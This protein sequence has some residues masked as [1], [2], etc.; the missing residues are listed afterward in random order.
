MVAAQAAQPRLRGT[1]VRG[2]LGIWCETGMRR[3]ASIAPAADPK[4]VSA[5]VP[6]AVQTVLDGQR[7]VH[8]FEVW[9]PVG[10]RWRRANVPGY[11]VRPAPALQLLRAANAADAARWA[12]PDLR[13]LAQLA[14]GVEE[15]VG[16]GQVVP[17]VVY[18]EDY[19]ARWELLRTPEI[20][21][22]LGSVS[23]LV[24][25]LDVD[26]LAAFADWVADSAA[27]WRLQARPS[28]PA[29]I[30]GLTAEGSDFRGEHA[31][32]A[33]SR[34]FAVAAAAAGV[35]IVLRVLEPEESL[36]RLQVLVRTGGDGLRPFAEL[37]DP[38]LVAPVIA[39]LLDTAKRAYPALAQ[40]ETAAGGVDF[41]LPSEELLDFVDR[42]A[43]VLAER[44]IEVLLPRAWIRVKTEVRATPVQPQ[45]ESE[46]R[47]G[48]SQLVDVQWEVMVGGEPVDE[49]ELQRMLAAS[50]DLVQLRGRWVR[51]DADALRRAAAFLDRAR[52][53]TA[54]ADG[55]DGSDVAGGPDGAGA[56]GADGE[57]GP[58]KRV[59]TAIAAFVGA[60]CAPE[61]EGVSISAASTLAWPIPRE[62]DVDKRLPEWFGARLRDY[63]SDGV[64]W[65]AGMA[66]AG[67]GAVL[68]DDMGLGKTVQILALEAIDRTGGVRV[69][70][71][72]GERD[73]A[74]LGPTLIVAPLSL[75][76]NWQREAERF[77]PQLQVY[78]HHGPGR[79]AGEA[80]AVAIEAADLVLTTYGTAVRDIE[81]LRRHR[82]HRVVLDEA[83]TVKNADTQA[84]RALR[85]LA[86]GHR[87]ALTGTPVENR[88]EDMRAILDFCNPGMFGSAEVFR[89]RFAAAIESDGDETAAA[90]LTSMAAPFVLRRTKSDPRVLSLPA[91]VEHRVDAFLTNEQAALYTA[92]A[93]EMMEQV[94]SRGRQGRKGAI[95][96]GLTALKQVCDH[97]ALYAADGSA[98]LREGAHRSGKLDALDEILTT[99]GDAGEK[100]LVFTQYRTFGEMILPY[101]S[102]RAAEPVPF[103]SGASSPTARAEMVEAFQR[104]DGPPVFLASL[105]AGGTGLTLTAANHVV[106]LDRWWNPAVEDQ[107]TDRVHRIGQERQVNVYTL[108][109]PGTV[110]ERIA[111]VLDHKAG[112]AEITVGALRV[113][114]LSDEAL[115]DLVALRS[116]SAQAAAA[117]RLSTTPGSAAMTQRRRR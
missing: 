94:R 49:V 23:R 113:S 36:W 34:D 62:L 97:P 81:A 98:L 110:E 107:A 37:P 100:V 70:G 78:V 75:V 84:A 67:L 32:V 101:L 40:A 3:T 12:G 53:S 68:A 90:R 1:W 44:G 64:R 52:G 56:A 71:G 47:L 74:R 11:L 26:E 22:W 115:W 33:R 13:A 10:G 82:I 39:S 29:F 17:V 43:Q 87:V 27:R 83:Q 79:A 106:H 45:V 19:L 104:P 91:K 80:A 9:A 72:T 15:L 4:A 58:G 2:A 116:D 61:A 76:R 59:G 112:L 111:D 99:A 102:R 7:L 8:K 96:A 54:G 92:V 93:K 46:A 35:S 16:Q 85:T 77:A 51:A 89:A 42:G 30:A 109:A 60:V 88:L 69:D 105:R 21:S 117:H 28:M 38:E 41:L 86:A 48:L 25:F 24:S 50:S 103:L 114:Q 63:Q 95:L 14:A 65:L 18:D 108:V 55:S 5:L 73:G 6:E 66:E 20:L 31:M 57:R